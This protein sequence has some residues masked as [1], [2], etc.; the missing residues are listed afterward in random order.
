MNFDYPA[1]CFSLVGEGKKAG[2]PLIP[3]FRGCS[4]FQ[5]FARFSQALDGLTTLPPLGDEKRVVTK[6]ENK[7]R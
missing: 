1:P 7:S 4:C 5:K 2:A 3:F 6:L